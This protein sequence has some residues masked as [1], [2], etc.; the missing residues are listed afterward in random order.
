[1]SIALEG[2]WQ[3][4]NAAGTPDVAAG[5]AGTTRD[6]V[7][8]DGEQRRAERIFDFEAI[9]VW[10]KSG[11][12]QAPAL[13]EAVDAD[14]D[15]RIAAGER[16]AVVRAGNHAW[17]V[18]LAGPADG[19][20]TL[21]AVAAVEYGGSGGKCAGPIVSQLFRAAQAEGYLPPEPD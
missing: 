5:I 21:A 9:R 13:R 14:G 15:G 17:A 8:R 6:L 4:A 16:G 7:Y 20:P 2:M 12:A 19:S 11:T 3:S 1:M 18:A 10:A